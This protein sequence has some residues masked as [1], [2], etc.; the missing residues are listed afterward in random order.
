MD[1]DESTRR[2]CSSC[3]VCQRAYAVFRSGPAN[4]PGFMR[5]AGG[6]WPLAWPAAI[7][8]SSERRRACG[9]GPGPGGRLP[10]PVLCPASAL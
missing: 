6:R 3:F 2:L 4:R 5:H 9:A 7:Q 8:F 10:G 1:L